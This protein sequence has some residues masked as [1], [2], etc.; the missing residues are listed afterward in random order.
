MKFLT[1]HLS[2]ESFTTV[3]QYTILFYFVSVNVI[4]I[5]W[6]FFS[7]QAFVKMIGNSVAGLEERVIKAETDLG[8]FPNTFRKILHTISMPSFLNVSKVLLP[9]DPLSC[10]AC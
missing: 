6:G 7:H 1:P 5:L 3:L 10:S 2:N 4:F 9:C 8:A